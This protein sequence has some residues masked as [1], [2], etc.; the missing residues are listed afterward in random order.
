MSNT[1]LHF[2][3]GYSLVDITATGVIRSNQADGLERNQQRNWETVIQCLGLRTQPH[4]IR[5]P[6]A[7]TVSLK[8]FEFGDFYSGEQQIWTWYW[9]IER[10]GV[11]RFK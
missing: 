7:S 11:V 4:Y 2:F 9:N 1:G 10:E 8:N 5:L 6:V 3:A